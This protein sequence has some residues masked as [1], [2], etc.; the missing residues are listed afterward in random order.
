MDGGM[1]KLMAVRIPSCTLAIDGSLVGGVV[2]QEETVEG[3]CTVNN[4]QSHVAV[5]TAL[6]MLASNM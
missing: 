2:G 6:W 1:T 4:T 5:W 3:V